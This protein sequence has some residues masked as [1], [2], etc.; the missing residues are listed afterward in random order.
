MSTSLWWRSPADKCSDA[1]FF[2]AVD[3]APRL[4]SSQHLTTSTTTFSLSS[5]PP[6]RH[7][8]RR[9]SW[10][11]TDCVSRRCILSADA[12]RAARLS[13]WRVSLSTTSLIPAACYSSGGGAWSQTL[14][15]WSYRGR[16]ESA[17]AYLITTTSRYYSRKNELSDNV[18]DAQTVTD[19]DSVRRQVRVLIGSADCVAVLDAGGLR[20]SVCLSVCLSLSLSLSDVYSYNIS[21]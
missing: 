1:V 14:A 10:S 5:V 15:V 19:G 4:P 18:N 6:R 16:R 11:V 12:G 17:A 21:A 7:R 2:V 9:R 20:L 13:L 3:V 8:R